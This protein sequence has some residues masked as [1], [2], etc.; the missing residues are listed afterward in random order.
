MCVCVCVCVDMFLRMEEK[1]RRRDRR[2]GGNQYRPSA[3][4]SENVDIAN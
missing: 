1:E 3:E 2:E 4:I